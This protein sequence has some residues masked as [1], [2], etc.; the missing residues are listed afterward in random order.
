MRTTRRLLLIC[1]VALVNI[2]STLLPVWPMRYHLLAHRLPWPLI[3]SAQ[4]VTLFAGVGML[5]LAYPA[6]RGHRKA[7]QLLMLCA[8]VAVLANVL[9]GLDIEEAVANGILLTVLWRTRHT[10]HSI[11]LR[12]TVV[13]LLRMGVAF[14]V[15]EKVYD[16]TGKAILAA[17][18]ALAAR[19]KIAFP[20]TERLVHILT[21]KLPLEHI[22][23][24][25][26][27]LLLPIFL[28]GVFLALSWTSMLQATAAD[29]SDG[30]LYARFG[31]KSRNSL[32]YLA[33]RSDVSTFLHPLGLGAVT[34]RQVGRV[35]LQVGAILAP[36]SDRR[37][38]YQAF[39]DYCRDQHL[40]PAAVALAQEE[41]P[42]ARACGMHTINIGTE[43]LVDLSDFAVEKLAK[44]MRWVQRSLTKRGYTA[45]MLSAAEVT[46]QQ[47][48]ALDR[49]DNEW[50]DNRG[51]KLHGC[52]MT[53]GRFPTHSDP[54]CRIG[55]A[56][57]PEGA[58]IAYLTLLPGGEGYYSLDLTRRSR[59][60]PNAIMEYLMIE[61]LSSLQ[62]AGATTISLNFSTFSSL[63]STRSGNVALKLVGR[64]VQLGSLEAFNAKFR[65]SWAPRYLAC[66]T[67]FALPDVLYAILVVEGVDRMAI[68]ALARGLRHL[69]RSTPE[70]ETRAAPRWLSEGA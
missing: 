4:H 21:A 39:C 20:W 42:I 36:P 57:D 5:L 34:Y 52:C 3:A 15:L 41:R 11:P 30:D 44:K 29:G 53:L 12:Y 22:W 27:Q 69:S 58:P 26:S 37:A 24:D 9:K 43:A 8:G 63:A 31:R 14:V 6:A 13:D 16:A 56:F 1:G 17:L 62:R 50:R 2:L 25:Q 60:A 65:P 10:L 61:V 67:W 68:N 54:D 33:H 40:I 19:G 38:V 64:A 66:P 47:R 55:I 32:A 28:I 18:H 7:A 48:V 59:Q 45:R 23:F 51:G 49:I 35:A 46:A 70:P